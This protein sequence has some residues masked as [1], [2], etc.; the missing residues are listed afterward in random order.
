[1][2]KPQACRYPMTIAQPLVFVRHGETPW[3]ASSRYQGT[4]ETAISERGKQQAIKNAD[5]LSQVI[6]QWSVNPEDVKL[7]TSPLLRA[8]QSSKLI[9][10]EL[11]ISRNLIQ[12]ERAFREIAMGRWQ[13]YNSAQVKERFYLER[14]TR[15]TKRWDFAPQG[16]ESLASRAT[17]VRT[18]LEKLSPYTIVVTHA[19][20]LRILKHV[21]GGT[22]K[23]E[24]AGF[25]MPHVAVHMFES[26]K[27]HTMD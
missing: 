14:K 24:A 6:S 25:Q 11:A 10:D 23:E 5:L 18:A 7:V 26:D 15:K 13:G 20:I 17:E 12:T 9:A 1:M 27:W 2:V 19:G 22:P 8:R 4:T 21:L 3:N 16:G